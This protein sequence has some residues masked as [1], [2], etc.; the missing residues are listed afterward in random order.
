[1][2]RRAKSIEILQP[3]SFCHGVTFVRV[4]TELLPDTESKVQ[5]LRVA[6]PLNAVLAGAVTWDIAVTVAEEPA[7]SSPRKQE[8]GKKRR[9]TSLSKRQ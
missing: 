2:R 4:G 3:L 1:M 6:V 7:A 8:L 5:A 9:L